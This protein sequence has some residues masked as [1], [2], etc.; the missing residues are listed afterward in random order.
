MGTVLQCSYKHYLTKN[1]FMLSG[2]HILT[3]STNGH[4]TG[5]IVPSPF[6]VCSKAL[7]IVFVRFLSGLVTNLGHVL[8]WEQTQMD[9][10]ML[11]DKFL[12][13]K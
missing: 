6:I 13:W 7:L 5:G 8:S 12:H 11:N 10:F 1:C 4:L 9:E 2:S 3:D